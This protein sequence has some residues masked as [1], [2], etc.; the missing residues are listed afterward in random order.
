MYIHR[1]GT[2]CKMPFNHL[3]PGE[4]VNKI[5]KQL[6][7]TPSGQVRSG[8]CLTCTFRA[9]CCSARLSRAQVPGQEKKRGEGGSKGGPPFTG[10]YKGV[11]AVRPEW[12][13]GGGCLAFSLVGLFVLYGAGPRIRYVREKTD[14]CSRTF[15]R[16]NSSRFRLVSRTDLIVCSLLNYTLHLCEYAIRRLA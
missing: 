2:E 13:A 10:G 8:Q 1:Y 11:R 5:N 7:G 3:R 9:S 16:P 4:L 6:I 14:V 12:V 15:V